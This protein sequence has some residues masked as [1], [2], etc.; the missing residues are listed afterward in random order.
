MASFGKLAAAVSAALTLSA[1]SAQSASA[2]EYTTQDY[3][4][5]INDC[6]KVGDL[7]CQEKNWQQ[8]LRL[9]PTDTAAMVNLGLVMSMRDNQ[10]GAIVQ[11]EKA[12]ELGE[13]AWNLFAYYAHSLGEVG[14]TDEA[15]DWSYKTLSIMPN[16]VDVRTSLAKYLL[17]KKHYYEA[18]SLIEAYDIQAAAKGDPQY[19]QGQRIAIESTLDR[20]GLVSPAE[21]KTLRLPKSDRFF[22]VPVTI[23]DG[24]PA[25]FVLDTG[26]SSMVVSDDYL[27]RNNVHAKFIKNVVTTTADGHRAKAR[28]VMLESVFVGPFE[29]K[30]VEAVTCPG[31]IL[32]L[33][34]TALARFNVATTKVQG[35]E[36][37]TLAPRKM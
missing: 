28:A 10:K 14:R 19:F 13:G 4:K 27:L 22:Y 32:L 37:V 1:L 3:K 35:V 31:C 34:Q 20:L 23:G 21:E 11:Y 33:G 12:I 15:I 29:L 16:L 36:F 6:A 30:N 9:H 18:L 8:I 26:A 5:A 2:V 17:T 24:K 7:V 25:P